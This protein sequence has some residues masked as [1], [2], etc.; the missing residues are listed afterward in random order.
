MNNFLCWSTNQLID[1]N[2]VYREL[3]KHLS[4]AFYHF[5][6][7]NITIYVKISKVKGLKRL[8]SLTINHLHL[9]L[10]LEIMTFP[11]L[12]RPF[13]PT[14][15]EHLQCGM[16]SSLVFL[17]FL[18]LKPR[19]LPCALKSWWRKKKLLMTLSHC[20]TVMLI[21]VLQSFVFYI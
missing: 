20:H 5:T 9:L 16:K 8:K 21:C 3:F 11:E 15:C 17:F 19:P 12:L 6:S 4:S 7:Q 2:H 1:K 13:S 18:F 10:L 14:A